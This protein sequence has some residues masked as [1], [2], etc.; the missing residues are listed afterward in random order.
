MLRGVAERECDRFQRECS[1]SGWQRSVR[2]N[3]KYPIT[4]FEDRDCRK[5]NRRSHLNGKTCEPDCDGTGLVV[6][7]WPV[8]VELNSVK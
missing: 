2:R 7:L 3:G 4:G 1:V 6:L 8:H 5:H